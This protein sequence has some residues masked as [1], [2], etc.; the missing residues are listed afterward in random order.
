MTYQ[1]MVVRVFPWMTPPVGWAILGGCII[2]LIVLIFFV[3]EE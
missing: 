3:D 1:Q 2:L